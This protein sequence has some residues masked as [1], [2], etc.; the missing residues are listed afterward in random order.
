MIWTNRRATIS[1]GG[2][3]G[4]AAIPRGGSGTLQNEDADNR[5]DAGNV[6]GVE[7]KRAPDKKAPLTESERLK[8]QNE[9]ERTRRQGVRGYFLNLKAVLPALAD[10]KNVSKVSILEHAV[11]QI[12]LLQMQGNILEQTLGEERAKQSL[13]RARIDGKV[14]D[15]DWCI[16]R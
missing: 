4:H 5:R 1:S 6:S 3:N 10:K 2:T 7:Q 14:D 9:L 12:K 8:R 15:Q 16:L 13:L 11:E